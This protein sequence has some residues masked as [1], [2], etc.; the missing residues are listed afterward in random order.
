MLYDC[1][2]SNFYLG[3]ILSIELTHSY[4]V[5][6]SKDVFNHIEDINKTISRLYGLLTAGGALVI[7]NRERN[8]NVK[9]RIVN[10]LKSLGCEISIEYYSFKPDK[11]EIEAFINTLS[12][13]RDEHKKAIKKAGKRR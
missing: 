10:A 4:D 7:A 13:F 5:I 8:A 6:V 3:D 1:P 9:H 11:E 12:G 2:D